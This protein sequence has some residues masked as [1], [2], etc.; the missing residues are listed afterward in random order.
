MPTALLSKEAAALA[1]ERAAGGDKAA[2]ELVR[3]HEAAKATA[4]SIIRE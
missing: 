3:K 4:R 1:R 2:L